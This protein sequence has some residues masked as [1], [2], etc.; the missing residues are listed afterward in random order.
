MLKTTQELKPGRQIKLNIKEKWFR[1]SAI[2]N[3][4]D[5]DGILTLCKR[6]LRYNFKINYGMLSFWSNF[7]STDD[8]IQIRQMRNLKSDYCHFKGYMIK[9]PFTPLLICINLSDSIIL[10]ILELDIGVL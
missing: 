8:K 3:S 10:S 2:I 5:M 4:I 6:T 7:I 1:I 9:N